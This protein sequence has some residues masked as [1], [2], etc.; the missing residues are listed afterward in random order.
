MDTQDLLNKY[1]YVLFY[2]NLKSIQQ[3]AEEVIYILRHL[4]NNKNTVCGFPVTTDYGNKT[5]CL[6]KIFTETEIKIWELAFL[7]NFLQAALHYCHPTLINNSSEVKSFIMQKVQNLHFDIAHV[8]ECFEKTPLA[9]QGLG[10]SFYRLCNLSGHCWA[11][12]C[13]PDVSQCGD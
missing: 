5:I 9:R 11:F 12:S 6:L 8:H 7:E 13:G 1:T 3:A 10:H 2:M 4:T